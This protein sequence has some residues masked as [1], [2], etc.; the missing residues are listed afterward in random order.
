[1]ECNNLS[2]ILFPETLIIDGLGV[3]G[4]LISH[5]AGHN[6]GSCSGTKLEKLVRNK[7]VSIAV[8]D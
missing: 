1:M 6:R 7:T 3:H 4:R 8:K 5:D 2:E